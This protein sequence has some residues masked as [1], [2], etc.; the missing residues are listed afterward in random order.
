LKL[1]TLL[2]MRTNMAEWLQSKYYCNS[3]GKNKVFDNGKLKE[4][5]YKEM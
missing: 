3:S 4:S 5:A 1:A 2:L